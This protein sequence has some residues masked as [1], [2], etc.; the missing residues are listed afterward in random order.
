MIEELIEASNQPQDK[1]ANERLSDEQLDK[2]AGGSGMFGDVLNKKEGK[3]DGV[4][5]K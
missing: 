1:F 3:N 2:V 5:G 4:S